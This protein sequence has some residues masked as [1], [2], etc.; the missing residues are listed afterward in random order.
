M[1]R[2]MAAVFALLMVGVSLAG[3]AMA[4]DPL[5]SS[6]AKRDADGDQLTNLQEF[7]HGTDPYNP[8]SDNGGAD[9][10]WEVYY[11]ENRAAWPVD[12]PVWKS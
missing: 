10:G 1:R 2:M 6:D 3:M 7:L 8:D 4:L 5:D 9:D 12:S 11:D